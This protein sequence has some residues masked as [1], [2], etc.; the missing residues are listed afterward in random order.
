M[1]FCMA[2]FGSLLSDESL[3]A[4]SF[5]RSLEITGKKPAQEGMGFLEISF[6]FKRKGI[7]SSQYAIW[8]EDKAGNLVRTVFVTS[9][10]GKGGYT[11]RRDCLPVWVNKV[12]PE[13]RRL[14]VDAVS[15]ATPPGG[16]QVY[17]WDGKDQYGNPVAP[18][19]YRFYLEANL[20]WSDRVLYKGD[21]FHG[22]PP[23][24]DIPVLVSY[25]GRQRNKDMIQEFK[26][27][28]VTT[29]A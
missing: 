19:E 22:G 29:Q 23:Q 8:I 21:F 15:G 11:F 9:F 16:K 25:F 6:K 4:D 1:F 13:L 17:I 5:F 24:E 7:A 27:K 10:T 3:S 14:E 18:G 28:Y 20:Y 12:R 26:A 2:V